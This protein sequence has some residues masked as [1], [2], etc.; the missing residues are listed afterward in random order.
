MEA[1]REIFRPVTPGVLLALLGACV[2]VAVAWFVWNR[3]RA[4]AWLVK[5]R[6]LVLALLLGAMA[7]MGVYSGFAKY[8]NDP[9][10]TVGSPRRGDRR[11]KRVAMR[12]NVEAARSASGPYHERALP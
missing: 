2:V 7:A 8:T 5:C 12:F 3:V 11:R 4:L 9:P 1:L 10:N 6:N